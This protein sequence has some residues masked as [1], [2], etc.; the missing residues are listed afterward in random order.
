MKNHFDL[1]LIFQMKMEWNTI[2]DESL[3]ELLQIL[4]IH[5]IL[6]IDNN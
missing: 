6:F 5:F 4:K 3:T 1:M 2:K